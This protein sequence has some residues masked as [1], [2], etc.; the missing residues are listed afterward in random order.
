MMAARQHRWLT[1]AIR[2]V[3]ANYIRRPGINA[4]IV[5]RRLHPVD[6]APTSAAAPGTS[7]SCSANGTV[8][9]ELMEY[10]V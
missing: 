10:D 4:G 9:V 5:H 3:I 8:L 1:L 6:L 7:A 2:Y